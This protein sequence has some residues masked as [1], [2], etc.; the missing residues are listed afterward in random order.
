MTRIFDNLN[1]AKNRAYKFDA[2]G[3]LTVAQD[4]ASRI[5]SASAIIGA[6]QRRPRSGR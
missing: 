2:I 4:K 1:A 5:G 3:G 6:T